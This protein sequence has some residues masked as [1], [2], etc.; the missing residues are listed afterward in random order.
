MIYFNIG[1]KKSK[2][3]QIITLDVH[4]IAYLESVGGIN[5]EYTHVFLIV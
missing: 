3:Y 4:Q 2:N 5:S 1:K